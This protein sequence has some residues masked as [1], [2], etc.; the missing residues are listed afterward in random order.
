MTA[1]LT[2]TA[3]VV[4]PDPSLEWLIV[5]ANLSDD[6][7][8]AI[9][10]TGRCDAALEAL[11]HANLDVDA[12]RMIAFALPPREGV[13]WA[14]TAATHASR[15]P[16]A[17]AMTAELQGALAAT[18]QWIAN[19]DDEHRRAAWKAAQHAGL[20]TSAGSAAAAAYFT[21]GSVAPADIAPIPPPPA[22]HAA[23]AFVSVIA[24][25]AT[26]SAQFAP[27]AR[28]FVAQG[29]TVVKQLGGYETCISHARTHHDAMLEQHK[30]VAEPQPAAAPPAS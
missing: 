6:A 27:M 12:L 23:L 13:W 17:K 8:A 26:D 18:E 16:A 7:K 19:P 29:L 11:L 14:W 4:A 2:A 20:E 30:A 1:P 24:A 25:S 5:R 9:A 22:I 28:A 10:A 3:P 21:G 15:L